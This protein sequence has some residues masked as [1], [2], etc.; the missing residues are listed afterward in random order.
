MLLAINIYVVRIVQISKYLFRFLLLQTSITFITIWYFDKYL[1]GDY[2]F[3]FDIII[4]NLREDRSRF[5]QFIPYEF[6]KIDIYL[7]ILVF[8]FLIILYSSNFYSYVNDLTLSTNNNLLDEFIPIYLIWT[9]SYLSFLQIFR[10]TAVSRAYLILFTFLI[11]LILVLFRNTELISTLLGRNPIKEKYISFNLEEDSVFQELRMLKLRNKIRNFDNMFDFNKIKELIEEENKKS[12]INI[13]VINLKSKSFIPK[14]FE[15]YLINL[16]KK[17]LL[18][19]D[20]EINFFTKFIYRSERIANSR[21]F[22]IN[23]DIQYGSKFILKRTLDIIF[24]ILIFP[25]LMIIFIL[26]NLF[27]L[28]SNGYPSLIKQTRV[29]LHGKEFQMYKLR[30]MKLE[31]HFE[32]DVLK[33]LNKKSGPLFKIDNDPRFIKGAKFLRKYSIDELPQFL[34]VLKGEMSIVGPRPLF[35]ED[36]KYFDENY[37][38]R[39]NVLPGITG[40]LQ[41]NERNT[42]DFDIWYKYDVQYIDN[43]SLFLDLKIILKTPFSIFRSKISG[44]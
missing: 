31:S 34:N 14:E 30:T 11:P 28:T 17:I 7:A 13:I 33:D 35:P 1:I 29:G 15:S 26:S 36:N 9:A 16:N 8:I 39:L 40:L 37:I 20:S 4:K 42:D 22:Y 18:I 10:F 19:A 24:V 32:R 21:I 3:G 38:R 27:V 2:L 43:W 23:N 6:V 41:I 5:Y 25:F 44:K 12:E